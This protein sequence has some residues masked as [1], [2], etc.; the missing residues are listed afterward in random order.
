MPIGSMRSRLRSFLRVAWPWLILAAAVAPAVWHV[1]DFPE[2]LDP[3]FPTVERPTFNTMP[4]P[5]YRLAEP[6]DTIDRVSIYFAAGAVAFAA[7]GLARSRRQVGLWP[8]AL[9]LSLAGLWHAATPGPTFDG[10]HGLGWRVVGDPSAPVPLR[11][12]LAAVAFLLGAVLVLNLRSR[13]A[14]T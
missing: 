4:P 5:A 14:R 8:S 1:V 7:T 6:G 11:I 3:E 9:V 13:V 12:G 2:D 10:W